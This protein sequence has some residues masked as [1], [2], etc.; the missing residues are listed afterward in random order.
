MSWMLSS[1]A[2]RMFSA[3]HMYVPPS[4]RNTLLI[5][6]VPFFTL[7]LLGKLPKALDHVIVGCS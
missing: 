6:K 5:F 3:L 1:A 7:A 4:L 2:P